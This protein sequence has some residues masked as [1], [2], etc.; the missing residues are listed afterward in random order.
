MKQQRSQLLELAQ[1][2]ESPVPLKVQRMESVKPFLRMHLVE[3]KQRQRR[4]SPTLVQAPCLEVEEESCLDHLPA[5]LQDRHGLK[6]L[7]G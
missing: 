6:R 1:V 2:M 4:M 5:S 7:H 3:E